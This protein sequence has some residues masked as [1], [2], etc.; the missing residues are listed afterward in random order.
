MVPEFCG[1]VYVCG[2]GLLQSSEKSLQRSL[3]SAGLGVWLWN[4]GASRLQ[5]ILWAGYGYGVEGL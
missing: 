2:F 1:F 4:G 5:K 3:S